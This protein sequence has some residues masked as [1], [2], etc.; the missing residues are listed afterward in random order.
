META[1]TLTV[2]DFAVDFDWDDL[3]LSVVP[4]ENNDGAPVV[5][6]SYA[7]TTTLGLEDIAAEFAAER[8]LDELSISI[9]PLDSDGV[10]TL[11]ADGIVAPFKRPGDGIFTDIDWEDLPIPTLASEDQDA[12]TLLADVAS[13]A[14]T[15]P[16][17]ASAADLAADIDVDDL[18]FS[19]VPL[20]SVDGAT[21][22]FDGALATTTF[23]ADDLSADIDWDD[24]PL[25]F[26][27]D[28]SD[29][30]SLTATDPGVFADLVL[31]QAPSDADLLFV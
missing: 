8:N 9:L 24:V 11:V 15:L 3:L 28:E 6:N 5:A 20:D 26:S 29:A 23:S 12:S 19:V 14:T 16:T 7:V 4:S 30:V 13:V 2:E 10:A 22:L 18:E 17:N 1:Y 25:I 31:P 27:L 21:L